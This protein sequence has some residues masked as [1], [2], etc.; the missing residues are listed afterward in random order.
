[1]LKFRPAPIYILDEVDAALDVSHTANIGKMIKKYFT[2]SQ[3]NPTFLI[4]QKMTITFFYKY[5]HWHRKMS[6]LKLTNTENV[7]FL[8]E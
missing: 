7:W 5:K 4:L 8:L 3:V 6:N 2:N 1:M